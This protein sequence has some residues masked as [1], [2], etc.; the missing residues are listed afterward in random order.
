MGGLQE[1]ANGKTG[2]GAPFL[3]GIQYHF[4]ES[5]LVQPLLGFPRGV[6]PLDLP[7]RR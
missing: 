5:R 3:V 7:G 1:P 2:E 4:P 6:A